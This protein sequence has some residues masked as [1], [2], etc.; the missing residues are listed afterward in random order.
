MGLTDYE[1][2][3]SQVVRSL[4]EDVGMY[5]SAEKLLAYI[6]RITDT[7]G[8]SD[9]VIAGITKFRTIIEAVGVTDADTWRILTA[10]YLSIVIGV[11]EAFI[12]NSAKSKR[13]TLSALD[14][15]ITLEVQT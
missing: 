13:I 4:P 10:L 14:A 2:R 15:R 8:I 1:A 3:Y 5:D 7:Y 6:R 12:L 9:S 11:Y